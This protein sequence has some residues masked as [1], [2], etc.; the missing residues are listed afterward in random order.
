[1]RCGG[2]YGVHLYIYG[3]AKAGNAKTR[4]TKAGNADAGTFKVRTGALSSVDQS[5]DCGIA[6]TFHMI[7]LLFGCWTQFKVNC[8]GA[9]F[10]V[11][12]GI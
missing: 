11:T 12:I 4:N 7:T 10:C 8:T 6:E 9:E 2:L 3:N 5:D 1:M